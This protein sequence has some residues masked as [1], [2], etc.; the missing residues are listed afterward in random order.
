MVGP[1]V[2]LYQLGGPPKIGV[3]NLPQIM[4]FNR[5]WNQKPSILGAHPYMWTHPIFN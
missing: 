3:E 2:L 4:N 1:V 5:V